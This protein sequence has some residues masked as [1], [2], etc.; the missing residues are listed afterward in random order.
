MK[1]IL[2]KHDISLRLLSLLLSVV[3]WAVVMDMDN[4]ERP[5]TFDNIPVRISGA[6][7]LQQQTGLSL[8]EGADSTVKITLRGPSKTLGDIKASQIAASV[9]VSGLTEANE[10]DLPVS[11]TVSR[12]GLEVEYISPSKVHVRVDKVDTKDIPVDV[13]VTGTGGRLP[14]RQAILAGQHHHGAGPGG[15]ACERGQGGRGHRCDG[16]GVYADQYR[17]SGHAV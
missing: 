2:K 6:T 7:V 15:R 16:R 17:M 5:R 1:N 14:R 11:V 8:I 4:P 13:N 9:D 10:Y 3:L 12:S